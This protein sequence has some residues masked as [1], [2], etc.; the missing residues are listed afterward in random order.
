MNWK[1]NFLIAIKKSAILKD[2][3]RGILNKQNLTEAEKKKATGLIAE[4]NTR[5]A[6]WKKKLQD[7]LKPMKP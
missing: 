7:L 2:S 3:I 1:E 5:S 4:L 6:D